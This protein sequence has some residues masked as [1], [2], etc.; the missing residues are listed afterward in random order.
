MY[1]VLLNQMQLLDVSRLIT[2]HRM[3]TASIDM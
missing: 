2:G 1:T 3:M